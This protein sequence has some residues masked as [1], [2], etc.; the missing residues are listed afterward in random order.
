[1][2][3]DVRFG[4]PL[5]GLYPFADAGEAIEVC[6]GEG[7]FG[8]EPIGPVRVWMPMRRDAH[9]RWAVSDPG[10]V[11]LFDASELSLQHPELGLVV[12]PV[13]A[14]GNEWGTVQAVDLATGS[15]L[16][17]VLV[18]WV[19]LPEILPGRPLRHGGSTW[20]GRWELE[21]CG[22]KLTL[23]SR[24]DLSSALR[25]AAEADE[26][27]LLTHV[28]EIRRAAGETFDAESVNH[29][30][31]GWQLAM[32][33]ALG[34]WVA[35][36]L[37][38]GFDSN[39]RRV[40]EQWAPW[41]C[42]TVRGHEAWW[43]THSDAD[44]SAFTDAFLRVFLDRDENPVVRHVAMHAITANHSGTT[45]EG[46]V[47]LA[48]AGLEYL[49]WVSLVL[50]GRMSKKAYKSMAAADRLR[51]MLGEAGIGTD[52]PDGLDGLFQFA[53]AEGLD[54]PGVVT[55]ARNRLVH[56]K[57]PAEPYRIEHLVWQTAQLL[58][59]YCELLL[60]HRLGYHGG[61]RRRYPPHRWIGTSEP[62]PWADTGL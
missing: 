5:Q 43:N 59:E 54:G 28:G 10:G 1:M 3:D 40:W 38:N 21:T 23:D 55:W 17:R 16:D 51:L 29:L 61:V 60:L 48:Q 53:N 19:N 32:S 7:A 34:R 13:M 44:L 27:F 25:S 14:L 11:S 41:R 30:L 26:Q 45:A 37:P 20:R 50:S 8:Q 62:V 58:L 39:D 36:A 6:Q 35:P 12:S 31:F 47:M 22:W 24:L 4:E 52:V 9:V 49:S 46:K 2:T 57:D 56:P 18:H 33:F 42:D 15:N